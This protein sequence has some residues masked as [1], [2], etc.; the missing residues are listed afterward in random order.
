[1]AD[2]FVA[3][4]LGLAVVEVDL[5]S[6]TGETQRTCALDVIDQIRTRATVQTR[7]RLALVDVDLT[8][9]ARESRHTNTPERPRI[10]QAAAVVLARMTLALVH[11][12]LASRPSESLR[13][14]ARKRSRCVH[15]NAVV[16]ARR[17]LVALVNVLRTIDALVAGRTRTRKR[18]V[19]RARIAQCI[20]MARIRCA[21][22]VQVT[23]QTRFPGRTPT[24]E[25]AHAIQARRPI[26][27]GRVHAVVDVLATVRSRPAVHADARIAAVRVRARRPILADGRTHRALVH[28][29]LAVFAH[30]IVGALAAIGVDGVHAGAA[31]LAE[32]TGTVVDV[33]L[34]VGA[35]E[36]WPRKK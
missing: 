34:A 18:S 22:I 8:L 28:I 13:T 10:V 27:A 15:T 4:R 9:N 36:S 2:A 32:M 33:L 25:T 23:Q 11:V 20:R 14:V 1:M 6:G 24:I 5:A 16:F 12:R 7:I 3:A 31:V 17:S 30:V 29:V 26:E 35:L 19:D 21:R